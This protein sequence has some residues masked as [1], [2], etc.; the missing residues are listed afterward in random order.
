MR[1]FHIGL[2]LTKRLY[3]TRNTMTIGLQSLVSP[4]STSDY[5]A[6][7]ESTM[8]LQRDSVTRDIFQDI[9]S[10][11]GINRYKPTSASLHILQTQSE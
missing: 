8:I 2:H 1:L 4:Q 10:R 7:H 5:D 9:E 11:H 3:V 6:I